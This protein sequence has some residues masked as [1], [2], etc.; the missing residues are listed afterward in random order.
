MVDD[1]EI[2]LRGEIVPSDTDTEG[3]LLLRQEAKRWATRKLAPEPDGKIRHDHLVQII[4][5]KRPKPIPQNFEIPSAYS[6]PDPQFHDQFM[7]RVTSASSRISI[8]WETP[9]KGKSTYLSFLVHALAEQDIPVVRHHYFLS[10]DDT[11][12]DRVSFPDI[13]NSLLRQMASQCPDGSR[14]LEERPDQLRDWITACGK[15]FASH[16]KPFLVLVDGLDHVWR[17]RLNLDQMNHLFSYLLPCPENVALI[18]GTQR[19]P[20]GQL[21]FRLVREAG[22]ADWIEIPA[23]NEEA[24]HSWLTAQK[25]AGRLL[26]DYRFQTEDQRVTE[27]FELSRAFFDVSSGHPLHLIYTFEAL[28][29]RGRPITPDLVSHSPPCP[30]GDIRKYYAGLWA[31]LTPAGK[32]VLHLIAASD[33]RWPPEGIRKCAG[34]IDEIDHLIEYRRTGVMAFHGSI[35]AYVRE[36]RD[37]D[38]TYRSMLPTVIRWLKR[39]APE[40]LRWGWLWLTEARNGQPKNL[41]SKPNRKWMIESLAQG[42]PVQQVI[43]ILSG[44]ERVAFDAGDYPRTIQLRSLKTRT[45]N[46]PEYQTANFAQFQECAIKSA[47][48]S[49]QRATMA[50]RLPSL[51]DAEVLALARSI[52][53][54]E[55]DIGIECVQELRRRI[56]LWLSLRHRPGNEFISLCE[57]FFEAASRHESV[58]TQKVLRFIDGFRD[59]NTRERLFQSFVAGLT[60]SRSF[61]KLVSTQG[62]LNQ[63]LPNWMNLV[64]NE[65]V[66]C[67]A[68]ENI[69]LAA[70]LPVRLTAVSPLL[71]CWYAARGV[72]CPETMRTCF[73][74]PNAIRERYDYGRV[75]ELE[76]LFHAVF[77][78]GLAISLCPHG[79]F[80]DVLLGIDLEKPGWITKSL[81]TL[82][83]AARTIA[84]T[85]NLSYEAIFDQTCSLEIVDTDPGL[86]AEATQYRSF[87][88]ALL[89]IA[90]DLHCLGNAVN[91]VREVS[92]IAL[93]SARSSLHWL[94]ELWLEKNLEIDKRI[95]NS[96]AAATFLDH[97][98]RRE[99]TTTTVFN[100]RAQRWID[101]AHL[102][103]LYEIPASNLVIRAADC[104]TGYGW[105]KDTWIFDVLDCIR[106]THRTGTV[107]VVPWLRMVAPVVDNIMEFT[108]RDEERHSR[109]TLINLVAEVCPDRLPAYYAYHIAE[110]NWDLA[111]ETL[112]AHCKLLDYGDDASSALAS[113]FL[114][115]KDLKIL[116]QGAKDGLPGAATALARQ[117]RFLGITTQSNAGVALAS[118]GIAQTNSETTQAQ[119]FRRGRRAPRLSRYA[120]SKFAELIKR[121]ATPGLGYERRD[122]AFARWLHYWKGKKQGVPALDAIDDYFQSTEHRYPVEVILDEA[123]LASLELQGRKAAYKWLVRAHI[124]R[125][126]WSSFWD[127]A[128]RVTRRLGWAA[129]YY[130]D[131]WQAFIHDTAVP[132]ADWELKFGFTIGTDH[133]VQYLLLVDQ[134]NLAARCTEACV[135][136]ISAELSDQP[137]EFSKWLA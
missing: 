81:R 44:A 83:R 55:R 58:D 109:S 104:I 99:D 37:H 30:Q 94:D 74:S 51:S 80:S 113:T 46:G 78:S 89:D 108:D 62:A 122:E 4:S 40:F 7:R 90:L 115:R 106:Q 59:G 132:A 93:A 121:L 107:N 137:I 112:E 16:G 92:A 31:R 129:K 136:V 133:L 105:R 25:N 52:T 116:A 70:R 22:Q 41:I 134:T 49:Q 36:Q 53:D 117:R 33:F 19:V 87:R 54:R 2:R 13:A 11:T 32:R 64:E 85:R 60:R 102:A 65:I 18:I 103:L 124:Q 69:D 56:N 8:L 34:P 12:T 79:E 120:P 63:D 119:D 9:G 66:R 123:F 71:D 23:M 10:L 114:H 39:E 95:L 45:Q 3:W 96:A 67:A 38:P 131:K 28:V 130:R 24:V 50:D 6:L 17:D 76:R 125:R 42:W 127:S 15:Y 29:R 88:L 35:L 75:S 128:E 26:V 73:I 14:G 135:Q 27:F 48:N 47:G 84:E 68:F 101:L 72:P 82:I 110:E 97:L 20:D 91:G 5:K 77:F 1:L 126:G 21:P 118:E 98:V 43:F 111:E 61:E 100:T 57:I 86:S